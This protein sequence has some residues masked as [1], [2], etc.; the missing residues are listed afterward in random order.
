MGVLL[1]LG[2]LDDLDSG[3]GADVGAG[4]AK[5]RTLVGFDERKRNTEDVSK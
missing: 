2:A 1:A 3:V 4:V 5:T